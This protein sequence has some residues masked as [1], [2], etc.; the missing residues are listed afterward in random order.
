ME[1]NFAALEGRIHA[2]VRPVLWNSNLAVLAGSLPGKSLNAEDRV[3]VG[4]ARTKHADNC[5]QM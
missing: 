2:T 3:A 5:K 4:N 1:M